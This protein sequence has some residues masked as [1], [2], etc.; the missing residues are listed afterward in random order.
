MAALV[1]TVE[2]GFKGA[3]NKLEKVS[4]EVPAEWISG[5]NDAMAEVVNNAKLRT[6]FAVNPMAVVYAR[7]SEP[8][9]PDAHWSTAR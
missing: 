3:N 6:R 9:D 8:W 5:E 4:D 2:V 7:I 1:R